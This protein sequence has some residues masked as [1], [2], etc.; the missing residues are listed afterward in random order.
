MNQ[1]QIDGIIRDGVSAAADHIAE[2]IRAR[3]G[4]PLNEEEFDRLCTRIEA[5][6]IWMAV[7]G[8]A[9]GRR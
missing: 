4:Q 8:V 6:G 2:L 9:Q 5:D 3:T 7:N 1:Q